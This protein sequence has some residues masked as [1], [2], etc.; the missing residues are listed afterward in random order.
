MTLYR[1]T[2]CVLIVAALAVSACH[3]TGEPLALLLRRGTFVLRTVNGGSLPADISIQPANEMVLL[4]D[5]LRFEGNGR[6]TRGRTERLQFSTSAPEVVHFTSDYRVQFD[7][8][9]IFLYFVCPPGA[10][11]T[12]NGPIA[13]HLADAN[14]FVVGDAQPWVYVRP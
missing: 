7:G 8:E 3:S 14:T 11:C 13:G 9:T 4:A 10:N 6:A 12:A 2:L 1:R 5:T